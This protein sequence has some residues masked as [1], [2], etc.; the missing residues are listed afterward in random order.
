MAAAAKI[1]TREAWTQRALELAEV[2]HTTGT[3]RVL[4]AESFRIVYG[5][6]RSHA[7][8]EYIILATSFDGRVVCDC[9]AGLHGRPCCHAGAAIHADRQR[10][11]A[12]ST[13]S[14]AL[15]WFANGGEW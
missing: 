3:A 12:S 2:R 7:L 14:E 6:R 10:L 8:G 15:D 5:V 11:Q 4:A 1:Q 9:I 13:R